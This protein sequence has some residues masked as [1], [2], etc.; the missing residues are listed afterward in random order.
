MDSGPAP[1]WAPRAGIEVRVGLSTLLGRDERPGEIPG[2]GPVTADVART[3][4]A[5]QRRGAEWRFGVVNDAG[6]LLLAGVTRRRPHLPNPDRDADRGRVRGGIVERHV[7]AALLTELA[8]GAAPGGEW[9]GVIADIA[10]QYALREQLRAALDNKPGARFA[11]GA[12]ARHV[13]IRDR[14]CCHM[15]C[16]RPAASA[17]LDHTRD[18][19]AG[20]PT[21]TA[22]I[23]PNCERHHWYKTALGWRL[24]QPEAGVFE[25]TSPL[26]RVYRTRPEPIRPELPEPLPRDP[27][28]DLDRGV[29]QRFDPKDWQPDLPILDRPLKK[30]EPPP[31]RPPPPL[32]DDEPPPF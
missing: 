29:E 15:G 16:E 10:A 9:A 26:R 11:R 1:G 28:P 13:Q 19:A 31:P 2:L 27:A 20:G 7:S 6:Y 32:P 8:A 5:A 22:N 21:T 17:E 4:V 30:P 23:D 24:R 3:A 25:W 12:L 18:H 14:Y